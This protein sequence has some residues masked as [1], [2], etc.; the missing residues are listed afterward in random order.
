LRSKGNKTKEKKNKRERHMRANGKFANLGLSHL[1]L[2][3]MVG[4]PK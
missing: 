3:E 1:Y 4:K 2:V